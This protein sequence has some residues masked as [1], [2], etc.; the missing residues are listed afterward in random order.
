MDYY[1]FNNAGRCEIR[2]DVNA[3]LALP[4]AELREE[5]EHLCKI[6]DYMA[7]KEYKV[8]Q[9]KGNVTTIF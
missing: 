7:E 1:M 8:W 3:L 9:K 5:L 2:C 4:Y 6:A